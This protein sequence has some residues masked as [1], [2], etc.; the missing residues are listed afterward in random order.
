MDLRCSLS[1]LKSI[2]SIFL[3]LIILVAPAAATLTIYR[4]PLNATNP[5][6]T[7]RL[8]GGPCKIDYT[9][10]QSTKNPLSVQYKDLSKGTVL[11]YHWEWGDGTCS[12]GTNK[13]PVHVYKKKGYYITSETIWTKEYKFKLWVH[14]TV[15]IK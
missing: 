8:I 9:A 4:T 7:E 1:S 2:V 5:P 11:K 3:I 15:I 13:N 14:K 6:G 10:I 12:E